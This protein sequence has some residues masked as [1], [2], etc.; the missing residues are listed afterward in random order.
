MV[1]MTATIITDVSP[2]RWWEPVIRW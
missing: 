2:N 1:Q